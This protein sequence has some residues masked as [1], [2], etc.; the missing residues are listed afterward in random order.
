[1]KRHVKMSLDFLL[2]ALVVTPFLIDTAPRDTTQTKISVWGSAGQ[3]AIVDRGCSGEILREEAIGYSELGGEWSRT[4]KNSEVGILVHGV[5]DQIELQKDVLDS[6]YGYRTVYE[7]PRRIFLGLNPFIEWKSRHVGLGAGLFW[8]GKP[9]AKIGS[10]LFP[11][12]HFRFGNLQK[13]YFEGSFFQHPQLY[14]GNYLRIGIGSNQPATVHPWL[15]VGFGPQ[16]KLGLL[17]R[18]DILV[19]KK[20]RLNWLIRIGSNEGIAEPALG[21]RFDYVR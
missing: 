3:Y 21:I 16:D 2:L 4:G 20:L 15:G 18:S 9:P 7:Y 8:S 12:F 14:S 10:R 19:N 6:N 5:R 11:T 1:M 17:F 13:F